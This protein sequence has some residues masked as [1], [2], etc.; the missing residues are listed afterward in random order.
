MAKKAK[1]RRR[2]Q[3]GARGKAKASEDASGNG[4]GGTGAAQVRVE[5]TLFTSAAGPLSKHI[6]L[7]VDGALVNDSS[8]QLIRGTA[9]RLHLTG[10]DGLATLLK[11]CTSYNALALGI[12][13]ADGDKVQV[14]TTD[15]L[16][17]NPGAIA[18][19]RKYFEFREG[20]PAYVLLDFDRKGMPPTVA[21]RIQEL[22]GFWE[23]LCTVCPALRSAAHL[24]RASTSAGLSR[25][26][27]DTVYPNSGGLHGFIIASDGTDSDRFLKD[28]HQRC[29][30]HGLGWMM[31]DRIGKAL[32]RSIVDRSVGLP[33]R[34]VFEGPPT[35]DPPLV[36]DTT[37]RE[38]VVTAGVLL[39]DTLTVCPPLTADEVNKFNKLVKKD[40]GRIAPDCEAARARRIQEL[41][42]ERGCDEEAAKRIIAAQHAGTLEPDDV[43]PFDDA[44]LTGCTVSDVLKDPE[45]FLGRSLADPIEG[46]AHGRGKAMVLRGK[47][48]T[49][50]IHS[51]AHGGIDYE[52]STEQQA[53]DLLAKFNTKYCVVKFGGK[54][55]IMSFSIVPQIHGGT[56]RLPEFQSAADFKL[57][58]NNKRCG[59][60]GCGTW[61]LYH[62]DRRQF[63]GVTC[64][65][66]AG[67]VVGGY[68][69][70]WTSWGIKPC[71]G[72]WSLLREHMTTVLVNS[73]KACGDYLIKWTAWL[74]QHPAE[75]AEVAVV[76][77]GPRGIGKGILGRGLCRIG[78]QHGLHISSHHH[79]AGKFNAHLMDCVFLF[80]DEAFW[81][82]DRSAVGT[83]NRIITEDTLLIEKKRFDA[84]D[85]PNMLHILMAANLDWVVPAG[86]DERRFA[87]FNT[88]KEKQSREYFNKLYAEINNGGLAAMMH[89]L[90]N[91]DL[92]DWHPRDDIPQ[93]DAL[94]EQKEHSFNNEE[95]WWYD[96]LQRGELPWGT[97]EDHT[98]PTI[99]LFRSYMRRAGRQHSWQRPTETT[100]GTFLTKHVPGLD[101]KRL[102][103]DIVANEQGDLKRVRGAVYIFPTLADC[104]EAF[105]KRMQQPIPWDTASTTWTKEPQ[106][107]CDPDEDEVF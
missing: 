75:Q 46:P 96:V 73:D 11:G 93:T 34:L 83:L 3:A 84:V 70:L 2:R 91:M 59:K 36:Q 67:P 97:P 38:P 37:S 106:P 10:L 7:A 22:G 16:K 29:W 87:V 64:Q 103:Y 5:V 101:K 69:N 63:E 77:R 104:R 26:D 80:A 95:A 31:P 105:R 25:S 53:L 40:E 41:M 78:G 6:H 45:R 43:L 66:Q 68:L 81:P 65:P 42:E 71:P 52:L 86:M 50:F 8:A 24:T 90:M 9:E 100:L 27:T 82:G 94:R 76:L 79:L 12:M 85:V 4:N 88:A 92:G 23:A 47:G 35:L 57:F 1:P 18:R 54:V 21:A 62:V 19:S 89:D 58:E 98:C 74:F 30:L 51:Y 56:R 72:D 14:V 33:E 99:R 15:A 55:R 60:V 49:L 48:G 61:W 102:A 17:D 39:V 107:G 44:D 28:L 13:Q 32:E 20:Q